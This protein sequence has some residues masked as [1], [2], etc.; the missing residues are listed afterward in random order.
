MREILEEKHG[1][2]VRMRQRQCG[3]ALILAEFVE[4]DQ[5]LGDVGI[6]VSAQNLIAATGC[7]AT[8]DGIN[9]RSGRRNRSVVGATF[10]PRSS[11]SS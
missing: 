1:A 10:E 2:Q 5:P 11:P 3:T 8:G 4:A 7:D 6:E 9:H